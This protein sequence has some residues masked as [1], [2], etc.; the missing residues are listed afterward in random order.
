MWFGGVEDDAMVDVGPVMVLM[1]VV[2]SMV[3]SW[4]A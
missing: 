2:L 1:M 3:N 4:Q